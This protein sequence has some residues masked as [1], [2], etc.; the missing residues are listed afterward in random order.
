MNCTTLNDEPAKRDSCRADEDLIAMWDK[1]SQRDA[2]GRRNAK[3]TNA[4]EHD[5]QVKCVDWFNDEYEKYSEMLF[6]IPNGGKRNIVVARKL[7]REGVV[8]G[9]PDMMLA[10][11][12]GA[13]HGLFIELKN[14]HS[15]D[16]TDNQ[17]RI[18]FKLKCNGYK[19]D[20][21]RSEEDFHKII[22][23]YLGD[24]E[25]QCTFADEN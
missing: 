23:E 3:K 15:N 8:A 24:S 1:A 5:L 14:G 16:L 18:M 13:Y 12:R 19:C 17:R 11:G 6:A 2:R 25:K 9:I 21:A 20:V 4:S 22:Q 7:Q 10:I